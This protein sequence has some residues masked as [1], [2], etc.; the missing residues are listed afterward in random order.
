MQFRVE[1]I[2]SPVPSPYVLVR[3]LEAGDFSLSS[4]SKL[5]EI[6]I[7][8]NVSQP[9]SLKPDGT[10]DLSVFAFQLLVASDLE[11]LEVGQVVELTH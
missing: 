1:Y 3:Q 8:R 5:S 7:V 4:Q 10:P 6:P 2:S 9:R 11:K